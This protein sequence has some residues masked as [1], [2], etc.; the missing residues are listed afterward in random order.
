VI[1][2]YSATCGRADS[3]G[4]VKKSDPASATATNASPARLAA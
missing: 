1:K 2:R 4:T 3:A